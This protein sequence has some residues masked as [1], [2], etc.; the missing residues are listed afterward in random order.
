[1]INGCCCKLSWTTT[2]INVNI[3]ITKKRGKLVRD[4]YIYVYVLAVVT[5]SDQLSNTGTSVI[6]SEANFI[7]SC[8]GGL[9]VSILAFYYYDPSSNPAA[10]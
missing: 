6:K 10:Y 2:K 8:V 9:E 3:D 7:K 1:M 4:L 5:Y